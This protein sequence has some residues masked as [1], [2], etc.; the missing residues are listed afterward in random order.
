MGRGRDEIGELGGEESCKV[1]CDVFV[2]VVIE[3]GATER[4]EYDDGNEKRE[5]G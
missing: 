4:S 1:G 2:A 5:K 3:L